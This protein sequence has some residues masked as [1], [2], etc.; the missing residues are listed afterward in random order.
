MQINLETMH[1]H[2]PVRQGYPFADLRRRRFFGQDL[3]I[4]IYSGNAPEHFMGRI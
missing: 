1:K 2:H 3:A 4:P